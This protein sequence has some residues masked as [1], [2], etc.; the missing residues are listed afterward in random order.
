VVERLYS[1]GDSPLRY[2]IN[3]LGGRS[4]QEKWI[5]QAEL[6]NEIHRRAAL[7]WKQIEKKSSTSREVTRFYDEIRDF[8]K[9]AEKVWHDAW[10]NANYM[11]TKP[12]TLKAM[13]RVCGDLAHEDSD[14]ADGRQ[15]RWERRLGPWTE[16]IRN[17]RSEGFYER[18]PAKGQVE[19]VVR[20]YR[21]LGRAAD[22]APRKGK[23]E[24]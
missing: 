10:G 7:D 12:V 1:E 22:I 16:Q 4:K 2:K 19:R 21:E 9:A 8:F 5:L 20:I 23:G 11:V 24:K 3:R 18:F 6:F 13:L 17:F 14:P 15:R